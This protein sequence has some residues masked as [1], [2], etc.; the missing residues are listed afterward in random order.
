MAIGAVS[1]AAQDRLRL[2][3]LNTDLGASGP[4]LMLRDIRRATDPV[5]L[6]RDLVVS[7]R[8]DI[9]VLL[10]F[11]WDADH[12]ALQAFAELLAQAGLDLP[13]RAAPRPN[14]GFQT[15][16]DM[17]GDGRIGGPGDAQ[18]WGRFAGNDGLAVLSRYPLDTE[19]ALDHTDFL[20][21]DLPD[22]R[23][24]QIDGRP[25]PSPQAQAIQRLASVAAWEI[26]VRMPVGPPLTI[27]TW[28]AAPPAFDG[29]EQRN[30]RRN[31][32][33]IAF[34][35]LRLDRRIGPPP[36]FP[37][38]LIGDANL[39][40]ERGNGW[41]SEIRALLDHP[42]LQDPAPTSDPTPEHGNPAATANWPEGPGALRVE[43]LLPAAGL[44]VLDSGVMWSSP[45]ATHALVWVDI[46]WPP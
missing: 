7:A 23:L 32:D 34:W 27:M 40:P 28:H 17:D 3:V 19:D 41:R 25:F 14:S 22:A 4:G 45:A 24:P 9:L 6:Q 43:Y 18:G 30:Q 37:F 42:A 10:G 35:R 13:Y 21:R 39:D 20:W 44:H 2:A 26:P 5:R 1:A 8:P 33:E 46:A 31:A 12:V 11:D 38:A 36:T 15:G 29:P 16:H